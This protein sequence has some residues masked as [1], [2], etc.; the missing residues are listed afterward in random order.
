MTLSQPP[1]AP[2]SAT[3]RPNPRWS[4]CGPGRAVALRTLLLPNSNRI[5]KAASR[6]ETE[7]VSWTKN[8]ESVC[9]NSEPPVRT[10]TRSTIRQRKKIAL[11]RSNDKVKQRKWWRHKN[12]YPQDDH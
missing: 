2:S 6:S 8:L 11:A 9:D 12:D 5:F 7:Q 1:L 4:K 10:P 3:S